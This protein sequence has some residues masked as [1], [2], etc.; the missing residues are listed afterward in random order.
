MYS[1]EDGAISLLKSTPLN[2][3]DQFIYRGSNISSTESDINICISKAWA[4]IDRLSTKSKSDLSDKIK[5]EFFQAV[6]ISVIL[7][8]GTTWT[9]IRHSEKKLDENYTRM[10]CIILKNFWKQHST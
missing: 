4:A 1:N 6:A 2:L 5:W 9:W 10:L 7:Y 3:V 8:S